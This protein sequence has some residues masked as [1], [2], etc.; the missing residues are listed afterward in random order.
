[1]P[2]ILTNTD[3]TVLATIQD[4]TIDTST[5]LTF[6]GKNYAGYGQI[7]NE[8]FVK[9]L[10]NFAGASPT[11]SPLNGQL[12]YDSI[13]RKMKVYDGT[14]T[15][16]RVM[17]FIDYAKGNQSLG[18]FYWDRS[19]NKLYVLGDTGY[20]LV[21]PIA[22]T[23]GSLTGINPS[24][25]L[26]GNGVEQPVLKSSIG[27]KLNAIFYS[28]P[29]YSSISVS[30][31]PVFGND[32]YTMNGPIKPGINLPGAIDSNG[33]T[34]T[35]TYKNL[36]NGTAANA[37]GLAVKQSDNSYLYVDGTQFVQQSQLGALNSSL[38]LTS[39]DGIIVGNPSSLKLHV[40]GYDTGNLTNVLG[41]N[42]SFNITPP[43]AS[44]YTGV[45]LLT[46]DGSGN[47]EVLPGLST[48]KTNNGT[49]NSVS[50]GSGSSKFTNAYV[51]TIHA[52]SI[53]NDGLGGTLVGP[54]TVARNSNQT[55]NGSVQATSLLANGTISGNPFF[56]TPTTTGEANK[57]AQFDANQ[58]LSTSKLN[59]Q[60]GLATIYGSWSLD[61]S[62][63]MQASTLKGTGSTGYVSAD[64]A[65]TA[66]TI[67]QRDQDGNITTPL[68]KGIATDAEYADLAERYVTDIAYEL[69][70]VLMIGGQEEMTI[71][72]ER[73][74]VKWG[75]IISVHPA[76]RMNSALADID[77]HP[78]VALKGRLPCKVIG[79]INKGDLLVT[80]ATPG[81]AEVYKDGD[82]ALAVLAKALQSCGPGENVIEVMV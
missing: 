33:T 64:T 66:N 70:T 36:F 77:T 74:S 59:A 52:T 3:G 43:L 31:D 29:S 21:G 16:Y 42:I 57:L 9:L 54:W 28:S 17:P 65:G 45:L 68:F 37:L 76:F 25:V 39:D 26:D 4:G 58:N 35:A 69:G 60:S 50:I 8:N 2:Y 13:N 44:S 81:Y 15:Q 56:T 18:D 38:A 61:S 71:C 41:N 73:A 78:F 14:V 22:T 1:M 34:V 19:D 48:P 10:E 6:V 24:Q 49:T 82:S 67:V 47:L 20:V 51:S 63:T 72:T 40:T 80:S 30:G 79:P 27:S 32:Q 55:L 12:W 75:G 23:S 11:S 62:A 46:T 53:T 7:V 5:D